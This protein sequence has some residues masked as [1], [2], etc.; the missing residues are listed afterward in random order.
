MQRRHFFQ[1]R[2]IAAPLAW[3]SIAL[4]SAAAAQTV[5]VVDMVPLTNSNE[6]SQ[7]SEPHI[8]VDRANPLRIAASA[9]TPDPTGIVTSAPIYVSTDGGATWALN[10]IVPSGNGMTGDIT[11]G[12]GGTSGQ[13]YG[14][15]LLGGS[16]LRMNVLRATDFTSST[17]MTVLVD[18][19][20]VDQPFVQ[21]S[22]ALRG[23]DVLR[24]RL[25]VGNNDFNG[26][27]PG[28]RTATIDL[29]LDGTAA[30]PPPPSGFNQ[31]LIESRGTG[32][33]NQDGP[34]IRPAF[35]LDGT[36][37]GVFYHRTASSGVL[38]TSDVVVVRDDGWGAGATPFTDLVDSDGSA[39]VRV[40][41]GRSVPWC[42][43][44]TLGQERLGG[45]AAIAVSPINSGTVYI[46]WADRVG[47]STTCDSTMDYTLHVRRSTDRGQNWSGSD[48]RTITN[49]I[50]PSLAIN[51]RGRVAFLYQQLTNVAGVNRWVTHLEETDDDWATA[52]TDRVLH[53]APAN[54][55]AAT[56]LPYLGDY[57]FVMSVGKDFHG[58]FAGNNTPANA[59]FP[60]GVTYQRNANFTT[61]QLFQANGTTVVPPSID[62][63]YFRVNLIPAS[64]DFYV[65]DWTDSAAS[66]DNGVEP[67]THPYFYTTSDVW[68]RRSTSP[69]AFANDQP[70][71]QDAGN[72]AGNVGDNWAFTRIRRMAPAPSG[73]DVTVS[74]H[75]LVSKLG[76]GSNYE[77]AGS[78][79]PTVSADPDPVL[80]FAAAEAGPKTTPAYHW[81]LPAVSSTHLCL[82]VE[83]TAPNDT[84]V[85]PSLVGSA[86]GWP[87]TDLR[88]LN[89]NNKAQRNMGLST[90]P[91][92][93]GLSGEGLTRF[94][95]IHNAATTYRD[96]ILRVEVAPE[97]RKALGAA[98]VGVIGQHEQQEL[99]SGMRIT[100]PRMAPGE[101]RW[102]SL[103]VEPPAG[104]LAE[105]KGVLPVYFDEMVGPTAVNGFALAVQPAPRAV[106]IRDLLELHRSVFTRAAALGTEAA[107]E[108][109]VIVDKLMPRREAE[110]TEGQYLE[111]IDKRAQAYRSFL[112][113]LIKTPEGESLA[114]A[115]RL[116]RLR[117][118]AS[119]KEIGRL[120]IAHRSFLEGLDALLT[121]RHLAQGDP[122]DV[123]QMV[124]WQASI[125]ERS[126]LAKVACASR[127]A[128]ASGQFV[129][130]YGHRKITNKDYAVLLRDQAACHRELATAFAGARPELKARAAELAQAGAGNRIAALQ[131]AHR[132][133]LLAL[134]AVVK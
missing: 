110:V 125:A 67:S 113:K 77:D 134:D 45:T 52:A 131:K 68:N 103:T 38:R 56:F 78:L 115:R 9:F 37:Y 123:L 109:A 8:A 132:G 89:D 57:A 118:H 66:G 107:Q 65:R 90:T 80:T 85:P 50:V 28:R 116:E 92:E 99:R 84:I 1:G 17:L 102:V 61:G 19:N 60:N 111:L 93:E 4:A 95:L 75:L 126:G 133:F 2:R 5:T 18:R 76:T 13:L 39:G 108:E 32:G 124:R 117:T 96:M 127:L 25:Y 34:P 121:A 53:T 43:G 100:L 62:P 130:A 48:L 36:V 105:K 114:V 21:G 69:G 72:G 70:T 20:N 120:L 112:D 27:G 44:S 16:G 98:R 74:A 94:A 10:S 54:V 11:L 106:V 63:F 128:K 73:G 87:S 47:T 58:V 6:T 49:A 40:V 79:D 15:I 30:T 64:S 41:T 35:N 86:P 55:P 24:D 22:T 23:A 12:F 46:A 91:A 7:D 97:V 83:V 31:D 42:S 33:A 122:A 101:N 51:S 29:N 71:N 81:R 129:Q 104:A 119:G 88:V 59:N 14:G 3:M 26:S 82:A